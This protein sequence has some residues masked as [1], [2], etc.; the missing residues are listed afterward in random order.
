MSGET[1]VA[2]HIRQKA[3]VSDLS[4]WAEATCR[5]IVSAHSE[6]DAPCRQPP[7]KDACILQRCQARSD[8]TF[9][10]ATRR[11]GCQQW[12]LA[13]E[14]FGEIVGQC[15]YAGNASEIAAH[16]QPH[17]A[18]RQPSS[19]RDLDEVGLMS[20]DDVSWKKRNAVP[21]TRRRS[22]RCLTVGAE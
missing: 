21:R 16:Q 1:C 8:P 17:V 11:L 19:H 20:R 10:R 9:A 6:R 22:L 14:Q 2:E 5:S 15:P 7:S 12:P 18:F 4:L 13:L 3:P